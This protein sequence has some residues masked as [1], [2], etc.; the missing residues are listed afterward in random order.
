MNS[1]RM[2]RYILPAGLL[3]GTVD[4]LFAVILNPDVPA[5]GIFKFIASGLF[6]KAAFSGGNEMVFYGVLLHYLIAFAFSFALLK[7]YP[8]FINLFKYNYIL[9]FVYGLL[10]WAIMNLIVLPLSNVSPQTH[11]LIS[12]L[13]NIMALIIAFGLPIVWIASRVYKKNIG[14][15]A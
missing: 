13:K 10:T 2:R 14:L 8:F 7:F 15:R 1:K 3:T 11:H 12:A 4:A 6:G 9:V 5:A